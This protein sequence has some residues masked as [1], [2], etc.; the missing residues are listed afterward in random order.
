M[1]K[2]KEEKYIFEISI[3]Y[4]E[5]IK[6]I[7]YINIHLLIIIIAQIMHHTDTQILFAYAEVIL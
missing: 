3:K 1:E 2:K 6:I 5:I 4:L 7:I